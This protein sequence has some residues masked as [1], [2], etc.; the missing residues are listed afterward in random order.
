M[1]VWRHEA[2]VSRQV[3]QVP[4]R[5]LRGVLHVA[6]QSSQKIPDGS[7]PNRLQAAR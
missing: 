3:L 7:A 5:D 1:F 6:E 4:S 2:V